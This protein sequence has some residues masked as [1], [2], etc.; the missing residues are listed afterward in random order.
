MH[1]RKIPDRWES[2]SDEMTEVLRQKSGAERLAMAHRMWR[3]GYQLV[4]RSVRN[5]HSNWT[6]EQIQEEVARRMSHG[7]I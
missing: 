7:A 3:F 4:N 2:I 6:E 1:Q 5:Q